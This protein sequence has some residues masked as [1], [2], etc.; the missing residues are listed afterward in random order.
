MIS[1]SIWKIIK[2]QILL[3]MKKTE[4]FFGFKLL[5]YLARKLVVMVFPQLSVEGVTM[6][7]FIWIIEGKQ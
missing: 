4:T 2:L 3:N 7:P 1:G 6:T 5:N